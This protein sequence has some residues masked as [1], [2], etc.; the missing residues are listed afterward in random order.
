MSRARQALFAARLYRQ[1]VDVACAGYARRDPMALLQ[2][3]PGRDD[4][5][6]VADP[7]GQLGDHQPPGLRPGAA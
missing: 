5:H 4:P 2:L 3:R 1:R 6:P 7:D